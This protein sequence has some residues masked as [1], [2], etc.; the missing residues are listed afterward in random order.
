MRHPEIQRCSQ[1]KFLFTNPL[2]SL[3]LICVS[4]NVHG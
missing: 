4:P 2:S 1:P 3:W